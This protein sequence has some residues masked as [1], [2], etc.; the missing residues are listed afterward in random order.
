MDKLEL[1]RWVQNYAKQQGANDSAVSISNSRSIEVEYRDGTIDKL[2]ESTEQSLGIELFAGGKYSTHRTNDLRKPALS[3]FIDNALAMTGYLGD[4]PFQAL[5][6]PELYKGRPEMDLELFDA[7]YGEVETKRRVEIAR[8]IYD[9]IRPKD[10]RIVSV[11]SY[12]SDSRNESVHLKSNGF[13]GANESSWF[14]AGAEVSMDDGTGKKPQSWQYLVSR[15]LNDL[16]PFT[17]IADEALKRTQDSVGQKKIKTETMPMILQNDQVRGLLGRMWSALSGGSIQQ[18]ESFLDGKL[19]TRI[20][21]DLL[22]VI[23]NPTIV[24]GLGSRYYDGD[25]I[26]AK[27]MPVIEQGVLKNYYIGV[28]YGRKLEMAPT[29]GGSSNLTC[30]LGKR[31]GAEIEKDMPR[32]ML[33]TGFLGGNANSTTGDYSLGISGWLIENGVRTIPINEMNISGNFSELLNK[34]VEVGNDPYQFSSWQTP[35]MVFDG[36]QFAGM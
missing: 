35:T 27:V 36:I 9:H 26:A 33:V 1:A 20:G 25:G 5:P 17:Q 21:S 8:E 31:S 10:D 13:E 29:C 6:D 23:D 22:T 16:P 18:K 14:G 19:G 15:H 11:T 28:Y 3:K 30:A 7:K 24:R 2:K 4:D 12:Y 32:A 34:L